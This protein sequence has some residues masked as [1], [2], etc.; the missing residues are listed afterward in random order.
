MEWNAYD[1]W[2]TSNGGEERLQLIVHV[3]VTFFNNR[4]KRH[5]E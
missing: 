5:K 4:S 2:A 3:F 1:N